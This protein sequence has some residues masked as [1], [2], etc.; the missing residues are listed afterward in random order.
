MGNICNQQNGP[1]YGA[2]FLLSEG[3]TMQEGT[4]DCVIKR[5]ENPDGQSDCFEDPLLVIEKNSTFKNCLYLAGEKL[6]QFR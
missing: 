3:D 6:D 4:S 2:I 1:D 5:K